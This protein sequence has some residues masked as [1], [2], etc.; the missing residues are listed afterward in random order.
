MLLK[1]DQEI[2]AVLHCEQKLS[3]ESAD[4]VASCSALSVPV[5]CNVHINPHVD[6]ENLSKAKFFCSFKVNFLIFL[7]CSWNW[8][9]E[10][11]LMRFYSNI[12]SYSSVL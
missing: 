2:R 9:F 10:L 3:G 7:F 12:L 5:S 1:A 4:E 6:E 8:C 11:Y